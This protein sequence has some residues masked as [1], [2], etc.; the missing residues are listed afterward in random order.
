MENTEILGGELR[1]N[2]LETSEN[3]SN[4]EYIKI[5]K[6]TTSSLALEWKYNDNDIDNT[7]LECTERVFKIVKLK[8]RDEW[9][10]MCWSRNSTCVIKNLEQNVCYSIK[11]LV[12]QQTFERFL[13]I[14]SSDIFKVIYFQ[15][16]S[17]FYDFRTYISLIF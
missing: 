3:H 5:L 8:N 9:E 15:F 10:T 17:V 12:M 4:F 7:K 14:D 2:T 11:I 16:L 1:Q 13:E 6:Q